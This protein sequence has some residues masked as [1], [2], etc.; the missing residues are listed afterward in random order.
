MEGN[1]RMTNNISSNV[2]DHH[3]NG[4]SLDEF[5]NPHENDQGEKWNRVETA[6]S[7]GESVEPHDGPVTKPVSEKRA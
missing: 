5:N 3:V 2:T 6:I 7:R 1:D 4:Q